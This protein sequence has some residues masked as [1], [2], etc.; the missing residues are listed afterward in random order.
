MTTE[1]ETQIFPARPHI[2]ARQTVDESGE[3]WSRRAKIW[4]HDLPEEPE[5]ECAGLMHCTSRRPCDFCHAHMG[6]EEIVLEIVQA[7]TGWGLYEYNTNAAY[8]PTGRPYAHAAWAYTRHN[9]AGTRAIVV[10]TWSGGLDI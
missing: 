9:K 10:V 3:S 5:G 8:S 7:S 2:L 4:A 6:W 1:I